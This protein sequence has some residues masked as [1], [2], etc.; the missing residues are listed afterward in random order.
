MRWLLLTLTAIHVVRYWVLP[1]L[2]SLWVDETGTWWTIADGWRE[3]WV[4]T[5]M[6]PNSRFYGALLLGWTQVAGHGEWALRLP[7]LAAMLGAVAALSVW[8]ERRFG[9]GFGWAVGAMWLASPD[10][11]FFAVEARP[12]AL[13][14]LLLVVATAAWM[15]VCREWSVRAGLVWMVSAGLLVNAQT[16]VATSLLAHG[17]W[18]LW[19][20]PWREWDRRR[21]LSMA[22]L[23]AGAALLVVPE[24][25]RVRE[26]GDGMRTAMI[27]PRPLAWSD[28]R[29][30]IPPAIAGPAAVALA[31]L[32]MSRGWRRGGWG[33]ETNRHLAMGS[34]L[35]IVMG[36]VLLGFGLTAPAN[37]FLHRYTL[38]ILVGWLFAVPA[39]IA[40]ITDGR[41]RMRFATAFSAAVLAASVTMQ[42][43]R[44]VHAD[45]DWREA[46]AAV[47]QWEGSRPAPLLMQSGL[48]E[49]AHPRLLGDP[50]WQ[51]FLIAPSL[52]YRHGGPTIALP[53]Y[54]QARQEPFFDAAVAG[55]AGQR[56]AAVVY[57]DAPGMS[58]YIPRIAA[59]HGPARFL[60][61]FRRLEVYA[62][63]SP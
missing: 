10:L 56:F 41:G 45:A 16:V 5:G 54:V 34:S 62:F 19:V 58:G 24:A 44:P 15:S 55:V 63:G 25:A 8:M 29:L 4:R 2:D 35:A 36:A 9:G 48:V 22:A 37:V 11:S 1:G 46:M 51:G 17:V 39:V 31:A 32:L 13:A 57:A 23:M 12:Y 28:L 14:V 6:H 53:Y 42:G 60:G 50:R 30:L 43:W 38:A 52:Y 61:R 26:I 47:R 40:A 59:R 20:V 33:A 7:S 27:P 18:L 21:W 3:L 49:A